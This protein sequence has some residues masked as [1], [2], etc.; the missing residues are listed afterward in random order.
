MN[1]ECE[2]GDLVDSCR[3]PT[4]L[5]M[6]P[7]D[8]AIAPRRT[9]AFMCIKAVIGGTPRSRWT[10]SVAVRSGRDIS[11]FNVRLLVPGTVKKNRYG[12]IVSF[13]TVF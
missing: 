6:E 1:Q 12:I 10:A 5:R 7:G 9:S 11:C 13:E 8:R 4:S 2:L 3:K